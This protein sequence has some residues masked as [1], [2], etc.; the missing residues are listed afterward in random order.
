MISKEKEKEKEK[1]KIEVAPTAKRAFDRSK[2]VYVPYMTD[3]VYAFLGALA[4]QGIKGKGLPMHDE[5][6]LEYGRRYAEGGECLPFVLT[7]GEFIKL[8][9]KP[10]FDPSSSALFMPTSCGPCRFGQYYNVQKLILQKL[11]YDID[12]ISVESYDS[13]TLKDL[14]AQFRREAWCGI[15]AVD[16]LQKLLWRRRP[17][18]K[19][20]GETDEVYKRGLMLIQEGLAKGGIGGLMENLE[21]ILKG[22]K[23][24]KIKPKKK[25]AIGI[26][27]EIYIRTNDFGNSNIVR[28][29]EELGGE[30]RVSPVL[31]WF[32]YINRK[33]IQD[34]KEGREFK[35][36]IRGWL[37]NIVQVHDER[38]VAK[39]FEPLLLGEEKEPSVG[40]L[41]K[42]S[43]PYIKEAYRGEPVLDVGKAVDYATK[44]VNGIIN[45]VPFSCMPG[46]M[47][48]AVSG[49][50]KKDHG[51]IPWLNLTFDGQF[52][53]NLKTRLEAL[54]FQA[55]RFSEVRKK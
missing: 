33:R 4:H 6:T 23:A 8:V 36:L 47:V 54:I 50:V 27:G 42:N 41:I 46:A 30:V 43:D 2:T 18:E 55:K 48:I 19:K 3:H 29:I 34:S 39:P 16:L 15:V 32:H 45:V 5:R 40:E 9:K 35:R 38:K 14:G 10:G 11:G 13:Y 25:P 53:T 7:L 52:Q 1:E 21:V 37:E 44:G 12:I 17:Y 22:F 51:N 49:L 20:K 31:E 24:I 26:I 28:L